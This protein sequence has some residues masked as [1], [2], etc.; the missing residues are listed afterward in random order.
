[1]AEQTYMKIAGI[2]GMPTINGCSINDMISSGTYV[3]VLWENTTDRGAHYGT[4]SGNIYDYDIIKCYCRSLGTN[5]E[6]SMQTEY[7]PK[8]I[9]S[10]NNKNHLYAQYGGGN[11]YLGGATISFPTCSS[12][13]AY[14]YG[15]N[16]GMRQVVASV[17]GVTSKFERH[18][19]FASDNAALHLI[20]GVKYYRTR[21]LLYSASTTAK[22]PQTI[23]LSQ[24]WSAYD[25]LQIK[26][27][28]NYDVN[29]NSWEAAGYWTEQTNVDNKSFKANFIAGGGG[30][31]Y[32]YQFV[33]GWNNASSLTVN[34]GKPL[35]WNITN[36]NAVTQAPNNSANYFISEIWGIK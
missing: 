35:V 22:L 24:P 6:V 20:L 27:S 14:P 17:S 33:G 5:A 18:N 31:Y 4:L 15:T 34:V 25:R 26:V 23:S 8:D 9:T 19:D 21:D 3:D 32:Y 13:S 11:F 29:P 36:N 30:Q 12:F 7:C 16:P 1:M 28:G 10:G 2:D